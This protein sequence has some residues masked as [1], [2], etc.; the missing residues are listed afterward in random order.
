MDSSTTLHRVN[1]AFPCISLNVAD[2]T[3]HSQHSTVLHVCDCVIAEVGPLNVRQNT[4]PL[5]W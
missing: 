1:I 4:S 5:T 2:Q 3:L